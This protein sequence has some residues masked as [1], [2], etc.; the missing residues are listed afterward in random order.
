MSILNNYFIHKSL[1]LH[2]NYPN[3]F[4]PNT[5]IHYEIPKSTRVN[6][7]IYNVLGQMIETL[8]NNYQSAG[9]YSISFKTGNLNSGVYFYRLKA[10]D[11]DICR[12][13]TLVT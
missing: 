13:M 10:G 6:L 8:V 12:Q 11:I 1:V 4:N 7:S 3:P 5:I 2:Q 9:R